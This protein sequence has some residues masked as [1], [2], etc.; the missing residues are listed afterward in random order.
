MND[1]PFQDV[2]VEEARLS[3]DGVVVERIKKSDLKPLFD[4]NHDHQYIRGDEE[5]EDYYDEVCTVKGCGMGRLI[6]KR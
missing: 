3:P 6:A 5:T 4:A 1:D 2:E